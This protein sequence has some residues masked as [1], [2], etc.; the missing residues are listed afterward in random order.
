MT[1]IAQKAKAYKRGT[2]QQLKPFFDMGLIT[3]TELEFIAN[4]A[5]ANFYKEEK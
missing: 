4:G 1:N 2:I 3:P 5:M